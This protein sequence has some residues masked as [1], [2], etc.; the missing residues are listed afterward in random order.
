[1]TG[2]LTAV[3]IV[4]VLFIGSFAVFT[5]NEAER[6][7]KFRLGEIVRTDYTPGLYFQTPFYNN[8]LKFDARVQTL[9]AKPQQYLTAEK[10]NVIVDSFVKWR[11]GD[12]GKYYTTMGG[13]VFRANQRLFQI[14]DKQL[15]DEFGKRTIQEVV[16]GERAEIMKILTENTTTKAKEFGIDI[17]DVRVKRVE[18]PREV[19]DSVFSRM[20][21]ERSRVAKEF[22]AR[23]QAEAERIRAEADR[24]YTVTVAEAY[25]DS[26]KI[27]GDG[28][29]KAAETYARAYDK[30]REFY[31]LYRSLDA[32]KNIFRQQDDVIIFEPDSDFFKYFKKSAPK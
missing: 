22:R 19:S 24:N 4:A 27:R 28:D 11:I 32:Y 31:S 21:A 30:N 7:V 9:D 10:K 20:R 6:A 2:R 26:Q 14:A 23:G 15:R 5:V 1:M 25:R 29:A 16:S 12:V 3:L 18:L 17:V 13:D 8:V